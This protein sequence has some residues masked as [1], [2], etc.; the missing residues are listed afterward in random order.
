MPKKAERVTPLPDGLSPLL[1]QKQVET[2]YGVSDWTVLRWIEDGM[3]VEPMTTTG[4]QR[5][6]RRFDLAAVKAWHAARE[7]AATA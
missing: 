4:Q 5:A 7:L 6:Q 2:Y 1:T 3:P